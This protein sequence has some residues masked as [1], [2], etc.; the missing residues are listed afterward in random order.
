MIRL[1]EILAGIVAISLLAALYVAK[2]GAAGDRAELADLQAELA[3]ERGRIS[4]LSLE[5]E[6]QEKDENLRR[7]ARLYLG[8]EPVRGDQE[9]AF[10][11]LPRFDTTRQA[12][13]DA[14]LVRAQ[15]R[16]DDGESLRP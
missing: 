7:L 16:L 6:H 12:E 10:T 1:A 4:S 3:R 5:I 14:T 11:E 8:F 9:I 15:M 13:T 2:T